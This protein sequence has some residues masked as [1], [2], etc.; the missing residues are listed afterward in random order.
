MVTATRWCE[1]IKLDIFHVA[2]LIN[3]EDGRLKSD[4]VAYMSVLHEGPQL[5]F[6]SVG[7]FI[8]IG[9]SWVCSVYSLAVAGIFD[10]TVRTGLS[11]P[12]LFP[13]VVLSV[14]SSPEVLYDLLPSPVWLN[15][16][17]DEFVM[18][19]VAEIGALGQVRVE[20]NSLWL[21]L[22]IFVHGVSGTWDSRG[23]L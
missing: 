2:E 11:V 21:R 19:A 20:P 12:E 3:G 15:Q 14:P 5:G 22:S 16:C 17:G 10:L 8:F 1:A 7:V 23:C 9:S 4:L 18:E 13:P 6:P